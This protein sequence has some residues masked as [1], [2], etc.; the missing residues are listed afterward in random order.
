M[1][2]NTDHHACCAKHYIPKNVS[3]V[4]DY[5]FEAA[6]LLL[7]SLP[8][9]QQEQLNR[10]GGRMSSRPPHFK[11]RSY[12]GME[13]GSFLCTPETT[14]PL[15]SLPPAPRLRE[16]VECGWFG[17]SWQTARGLWWRSDWIK[18]HRSSHW[19][20]SSGKQD[21]L[22]WLGLHSR[23]IHYCCIF[24]SSSKTLFFSYVTAH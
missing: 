15:A 19:A 6:G 23:I 11:S 9:R 3:N 24:A 5:D 16:Q 4:T 7:I 20:P 1:G 13:R 22:L 21:S 8:S 2:T 17:H 12:C 14:H 10:R 18:R